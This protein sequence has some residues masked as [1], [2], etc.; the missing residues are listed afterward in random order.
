MIIRLD[1][2]NEVYGKLTVLEKA[3]NAKNGQQ[4]WKCKCE[5][6]KES[7]VQQGHLRGGTT[8]SCGKCN[9]FSSE[10]GITTCTVANGKQFIFDSND[11]DLVIKYTWYVDVLGYALAHDKGKIIKLHRLLMHPPKNMYVDHI[12]RNPMNNTRRNLR[13]CS[14]HQNCF[15]QG[16]RSDNTTGY[17]GVR[18][19]KRGKMLVVRIGFK[20]K[21][22]TIGRFPPEKIK[23][24]AKAYN[25]KAIELFGEYAFLNAIEKRGGK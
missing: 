9:K 8:K 23:E 12:D 19:D 4:M 25:Q 10:N 16:L 2:T 15:N 7:I 11:L 1:L 3:Y 13:I 18:Y 5:C 22:Y 6:G 14:T 21:R 24:A 20:G 17:K